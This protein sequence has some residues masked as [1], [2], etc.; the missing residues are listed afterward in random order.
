MKHIFPLSPTP[1][2]LFLLIFGVFGAER[3][4]G[5]APQQPSTHAAAPDRTGPS[6]EPAAYWI[7]LDGKPDAPT[8]EINERARAR[9]A[10]RGQ[11]YATELDQSVSPT[12]IRTLEGQRG[13][14]PGGK[15][16]A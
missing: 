13:A 3:V 8:V 11:P 6:A 2:W 16:L 10:R 14:N 15:P 9:R 4:S 7:F 12:Y 5:Q 1:L